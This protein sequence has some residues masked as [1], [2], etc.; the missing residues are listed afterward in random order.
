MKIS[1]TFKLT[2]PAA[3][4]AS[5]PAAP[6]APSEKAHDYA[7]NEFR[8]KLADDWRQL[9]TP[10]DNSFHYYSDA[11]KAAIIISADFYAIPAERQAA[12][13]ERCLAAREESVER[14]APGQVTQFHRSI[15]PH[16]GGIGLELSLGAEVPG[17]NIHLYLGYVTERKIFNLTMVCEPDRAAAESLFNQVVAN[18]GVKLP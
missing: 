5:T 8:I 11:L 9:P 18:L 10:E 14:L 4:P 2:P 3:P 16:S 6:P 13:A 1:Y 17:K 12:V 7:Y 15:Q